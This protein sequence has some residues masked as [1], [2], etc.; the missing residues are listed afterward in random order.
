M[1]ATRLVASYGLTQQDVNEDGYITDVD[2][3]IAIQVASLEHFFI[4]AVA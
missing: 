1:F 4:Y 2:L 3:S